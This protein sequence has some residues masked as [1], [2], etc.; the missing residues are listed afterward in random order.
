MAAEAHEHHE[1]AIS[2][3][4]N[5]SASKVL[6]CRVTQMGFLRHLTNKTIMRSHVLSTSQAWKKCNAFL[7]LRE[8]DAMPEPEGIDSYLDRFC[9]LGRTSPNF[10]TDAYL[11]AFAS[12]ADLRLVTFDRGFSKFRGLDLKLL[13]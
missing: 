11:A 3:W 12:A 6:F 9:E 8:V 13:S 4:N 7:N 10:W 5:D 2:Y 1:S